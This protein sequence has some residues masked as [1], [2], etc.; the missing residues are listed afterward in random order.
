MQKQDNEKEATDRGQS[1]D[2]SGEA[3]QQRPQSAASQQSD[4]NSTLKS[5][6]RPGSKARRRRFLAC[7]GA[8]NGSRDNLAAP[9]DQLHPLSS[10]DEGPSSS[11]VGSSSLG[12]DSPRVPVKE[13][14]V[15]RRIIIEDISDSEEARTEDEGSRRAGRKR[16][17]VL[18][19]SE[20]SAVE[21]AEQLVPDDY[22]IEREPPLILNVGPQTYG[23]RMADGWAQTESKLTSG[24]PANSSRA[25]QKKRRSPLGN[26]LG[27]RRA[28]HRQQLTIHCAPPSCSELAPGQAEAGPEVR[29]SS[30]QR[31]ASKQE[32]NQLNSSSN[33]DEN[34][35][36]NQNQSDNEATPTNK[37]TALRHA[38][39]R[40]P[41]GNELKMRT[42]T[43]QTDSD[44]VIV[45]YVTI[46]PNA[47]TTDSSGQ[48]LINDDGYV[49]GSGELKRQQK[50]QQQQ[51]QQL[52]KGL[53][54]P[55]CASSRVDEELED[56]SG[57]S[58]SADEPAGNQQQQR[59]RKKKAK[60]GAPPLPAESGGQK[61]HQAEVK[62]RPQDAGSQRVELEPVSLQSE[63]EEADESAASKS[64]LAQPE[65]RASSPP[66]AAA[67]SSSKELKQREKLEKLERAKREKLERQQRKEAQEAQARAL[68]EQKRAEK[69]QKKAEKLALKRRSQ[70]PTSGQQKAVELEAAKQADQTQG[71]VAQKSSQSVTFAP[72][73]VEVEATREEKQK[74]Q[75]LAELDGPQAQPQEDG[76][77]LLRLSIGAD[78]EALSMQSSP[79]S[80]PAP[81]ETQKPEE[82]GAESGQ[83]EP[84][85]EKE[86]E[87]ARRFKLNLEAADF[88]AKLKLPKLAKL[89]SPK[90]RVTD[91]GEQTTVSGGETTIQQ[92]RAPKSIL[93]QS[94]SADEQS[95]AAAELT[96]GEPA[97]GFSS[98]ASKL[99][100]EATD[101]AVRAAD[102]LREE[103][104]SR[105]EGAAATVA[106]SSPES[107][108]SCESS[109]KSGAA[110][111]KQSKR[112]LSKQM[113]REQKRLKREA[114]SLARQAER[115]CKRAETEAS[116]AAK[117]AFE[118]AERQASIAKLEADRAM[119]AASASG[120]QAEL[121]AAELERQMKKVAKLADEQAKR[122]TKEAER[123]AKKLAKRAQK[124]AAKKGSQSA[125]LASPSGTLSAPVSDSGDQRQSAVALEA[126]GELEAGERK[127]Q[128]LAQTSATSPSEQTDESRRESKSVS[129]GVSL[130]KLK[131]K[132]KKDKKKAAKE[133]Q[134]AS[135]KS[136]QTADSTESQSAEPVSASAEVGLVSGVEL[137]SRAAE[138]MQETPVE[139]SSA[140]TPLERA[141]QSAAGEHLAAEVSSVAEQKSSPVEAISDGKLTEKEKKSKSKEKK[142]QKKPKKR[143]SRQDE[144][145]TSISSK[146]S[147]R[148]QTGSK[149]S[150]WARLFR[151]KN[152]TTKGQKLPAG[153]TKG[154]ASTSGQQ[155]GEQVAHS[156][157]QEAKVEEK[158]VIL[159]EM[160]PSDPNNAD[161]EMILEVNVPQNLI[162]LS[163]GAR[164]AASLRETTSGQQPQTLTSSSPV[165]TSSSD[166]EDQEA[167]LVN[168]SQ[169]VDDECAPDEA[170]ENAL[171][172]AND[173]PAEL[174]AVAEQQQQSP[175]GP[176][177]VRQQLETSE[178]VSE[179][180]TSQEGAPKLAHEP[181]HATEVA[182]KSEQQQQ[183]AQ[184]T[185]SGPEVAGDLVEA[186]GEEKLTEK[187]LKR[188]AKEEAKL[189]KKEEKEAK[190]R[191]EM[192]KKR[193]AEEEKRRKK[194]ELAEAKRL[195]KLAKKQAKEA[196]KEAKRRVKLEKRASKTTTTVED[197]GEKRRD[198]PQEVAASD[199]LE[200][201]KEQPEGKKST[202]TIKTT[203]TVSIRKGSDS[204]RQ[205]GGID[206]ENGNTL[207]AQEGP[208]KGALDTKTETIVTTSTGSEAG[209]QLHVDTSNMTPVNEETEVEK[210][211]EEEVGE[212]GTVTKRTKVV[213]TKYVTMRQEEIRMGERRDIP[214]EEWNK[215]QAAE[216][217]QQLD[218]LRGA[219]SGSSSSTE[220]MVKQ[221]KV[222]VE[223]STKDKQQLSTVAAVQPH[224]SSAR[225]V[226]PFEHKELD[227][228]CATPSYFSPLIRPAELKEDLSPKRELKLRFKLNKK[229]I[230]RAHRLAKGEAKRAS[231]EQKRAQSEIAVCDEAAKE[232]CKEL[233][234]AVRESK[235]ASKEAEKMH[236]KM[237]KVD[238]KLSKRAEKLEKRQRKLDKRAAKLAKKAAKKQEKQAQK[239]DKKNKKRSTSPSSASSGSGSGS[240]RASIRRED[241]GQPVLRSSSRMSIGGAEIIV[242]R[243]GE[244]SA[245]PPGQQAEAVVAEGQPESVSKGETGAK[246]GSKQS[247]EGPETEVE[248]QREAEKE[249]DDE[250]VIDVVGDDEHLNEAEQ[251]VESGHAQDKPH[252]VSV[253][254]EQRA[255]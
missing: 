176:T 21:A 90:R 15:E 240:K 254:V 62:A 206:L 248:G 154:T 123:E 181:Q 244:D 174:P 233:K 32:E 219:R 229:L 132:A 38:P 236:K 124:E 162:E 188:R 158:A 133:A 109:E 255:E 192:E 91:S 149:S 84:A 43:I 163:S 9:E 243:P 167:T 74:R 203:S 191:A 59:G 185:G 217:Q 209:D 251:S 36:Q 224:F 199:A 34:E 65:T 17:H 202:T 82:L 99:V 212:D 221:I 66:S 73:S 204:E 165:P 143:R 197:E 44:S 141:Q 63:G 24:L 250:L 245:L 157:E 97:G 25:H 151:S 116:R 48:L 81:V 69:E 226:A 234:R 118:E 3:A 186:K 88:S 211:V 18:V 49:S 215:M 119:R 45:N 137:E 26:V 187:E 117:W 247:L 89:T 111:E 214:L 253:A 33:L 134:T 30:R 135:P 78:E 41:V 152:A 94:S 80:S 71:G 166:Q 79:A 130:P 190:K 208:S 155:E 177:E 93:K 164:Q 58:L 198:E 139:A 13:K 125:E 193:L 72:T 114:K 19:A 1:P 159:S 127:S 100:S 173:L 223:R 96:I 51:Q 28:R 228:I 175:A 104:S 200:E 101:E 232:A 144:E 227:Q 168:I 235:R 178:L 57:S 216:Q 210:I 153:K 213:E 22:Y 23:K 46:Y 252:L 169:L 64:S 140:Q 12:G 29:P 172:Q 225:P 136:S 180:V 47:Q 220:S 183:V 161:G 20:P 86:K 238:K 179:T 53:F 42:S 50:Q 120:E 14:L 105:P 241:I 230:K 87:K 31:S 98:I 11:S 184:E 5:S 108:T 170:T 129:F 147:S 102:E 55:F 27:G 126:S 246:S 182:S 77:D 171:S 207:N 54:A 150:F 56:A 115:A 70:S 121:S 189:R 95:A 239:E 195:E 194:G 138:E 148:E 4:G 40:K 35:N 6:S 205:A 92:Q 103:S 113:A 61:V 68:K 106:G 222:Q 83:Q 2:L 39:N 7:F 146:E 196:E 128:E 8:S 242:H 249:E 201:E 60:K 237:D 112:Q 218:T 145:S 37:P 110:D 75:D 131:L 231:K 156:K 10:S 122:I 16:R 76:R 160:Y 107:A 85:K 142:K 52:A 67:T